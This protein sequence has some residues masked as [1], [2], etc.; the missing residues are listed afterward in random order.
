MRKLTRKVADEGDFELLNGQVVLPRKF[1]LDNGYLREEDAAF[2]GG[3]LIEGTG[4]LYSDVDVHIIT[5]ELLLERDIDLKRHYRVLSPDRTML[6][7]DTPSLEV[8][9]IHTVVPGTHIKVDI[10]YRTWREIELLV[11]QVRDTFEYAARSLM[12][13][14]KYISARDM[15]FIHRLFNSQALVGNISL[16]Q[17]RGKIGLTR[18]EYLMYRWKAS[19]FSVLLDMLGAWVDKDW[20]RCADMARENM[21]TQF[22]AYSHLCGNTNYHRKWIIS[23]AWRTRI[24]PELIDCYLRLLSAGFGNDPEAHRTYILATLDFVDNLFDASQHRLAIRRECP[25]GEAA[26]A[27]IDEHVRE[28]SGE[29]SEMEVTYRKKAYG[30]RGL[31]TREWFSL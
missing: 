25:S 18:F 31:A 22:Q 29:Y 9:L 30:A 23:Y 8:F 5:R 7:G 10:E 12:L 15:A 27:M 17:L 14:T 13:L 26:R 21:V 19:D 24:E 6:R 3:S 2:V 16:D 20:I 28:E 11:D 4:N 1:I